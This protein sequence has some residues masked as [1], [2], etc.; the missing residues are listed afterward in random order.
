M[1]A[2]NFTVLSVFLPYY[3]CFGK[4][5]GN[6]HHY[7]KLAYSSK[8]GSSLS[9]SCCEICES[10]LKYRV[11]VELINNRS[12]IFTVL[13]QVSDNCL[14]NSIYK[15]LKLKFFMKSSDDSNLPWL[16]L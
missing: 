10:N 3:L 7:A 5:S 4:I 2:D 12:I 14:C 11:N 1:V 13:L 15:N 6:F 16:L 8:W 9:F